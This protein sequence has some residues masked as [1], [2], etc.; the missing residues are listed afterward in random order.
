MSEPKESNRSGNGFLVAGIFA[1][2]GASACCEGGLKFLCGSHSEMRDGS[3]Q[4]EASKVELIMPK[5]AVQQ[6]QR[7]GKGV[8]L[9]QLC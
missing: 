9:P 1:T 3:D 7:A 2:L 4:E 6:S 8:T 5:R